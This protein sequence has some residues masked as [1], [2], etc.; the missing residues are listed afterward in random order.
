[1][2]FATVDILVDYMYVLR[3]CLPAGQVGGRLLSFSVVCLFPKKT[4]LSYKWTMYTYVRIPRYLDQGRS[5]L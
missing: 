1:M 3:A 4:Y 5:V 2:E